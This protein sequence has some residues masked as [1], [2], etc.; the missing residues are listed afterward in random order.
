MAATAPSPGGWDEVELLRRTQ[1]SEN[2]I[3][4]KHFIVPKWFVAGSKPVQQFATT[5]EGPKKD[6]A[7]SLADNQAAIAS[8][9]V[10]QKMQR[11]G[12]DKWGYSSYL[13][14][15]A[16]GPHEENRIAD[17]VAAAVQHMEKERDAWR[18]VAFQQDMVIST[19]VAALLAVRGAA[20]G[21]LGALCNR[22]TRAG[23]V[24]AAVGAAAFEFQLQAVQ[25]CAN[26]FAA[27]RA[28]APALPTFSPTFHPGS[29]FQA[30]PRKQR[31]RKGR[32]AA[33]AKRCAFAKADPFSEFR[34][35]KSA[36]AARFAKLRCVFCAVCCCVCA[37]RTEI[38]FGANCQQ[39]GN[40][41]RR[42]REGLPGRQPGRQAQ[43][44][45]EVHRCVH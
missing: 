1:Y 7:V 2:F 43:A 25:Q 34:L 41:A 26:A 42:R 22:F 4:Y 16:S 19:L 8:Q 15:L 38:E 40:A 44:E 27:L 28:A 32:P 39:E 45:G 30:G 10:Q 14:S 12:T 6:R 35:S 33:A 20:S 37:A 3:R 31:A 36:Q 13:G 29:G 9:R 11:Q 23:S 17:I 18:A 24:A 21:F 5:V